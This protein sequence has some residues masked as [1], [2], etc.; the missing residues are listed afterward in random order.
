MKRKKSTAKRRPATRRTTAARPRANPAVWTP[1]EGVVP[2]SLSAAHR[3]IAQHELYAPSWLL[4]CANFMAVAAPH[5]VAVAGFDPRREGVGAAYVFADPRDH[6]DGNHVGVAIGRAMAAAGFLTPEVH[7][8]TRAAPH[9]LSREGWEFSFDGWTRCPPNVDPDEWD[10]AEDSAGPLGIYSLWHNPRPPD[11]SDLR[12]VPIERAAARA[13][14]D[15]T[16]SHL[17]ASVS[18]LF[19]LG[20]VD[21]AGRLH[22]VAEAS[23][24]KARLLMQ[25]G[26]VEVSRVA[27]DGTPHA[28]SRAL[29]A[30]TR[31]LLA[32]GHRRIVSYTLLGERGTSYRGAGWRP[33]ALSRGGDWSRPSRARAKAVQSGRKVRWETGPDAVQLSPEATRELLATVDAH[34]MASPRAA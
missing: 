18:S 11:A 13:W 34:A 4:R 15:A 9:A 12:V 5:A 20:V 29:G 30:M 16:H 25:Q 1:G 28:A 7:M 2:A 24:P 10:E 27:S 21:P 8:P 22:C 6:R 26:A 33:V 3:W 31:T 17:P 14:I 19:A 23:I 32:L